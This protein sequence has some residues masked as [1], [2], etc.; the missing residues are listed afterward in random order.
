MCI[1]GEIIRKNLKGATSKVV[2]RI[3]ID[4]NKTNDR[5]TFYYYTKDDS[6]RS[7]R[8]LKNKGNDNINAYMS[9]SKYTELSKNYFAEV[10]FL[11]RRLDVAIREINNN[12]RIRLAGLG[13][14]SIGLVESSTARRAVNIII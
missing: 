13:L 7:A 5:V 1:V 2:G 12:P 11:Q 9:L 10:E 4:F 8:N 14:M 6:F 3:G